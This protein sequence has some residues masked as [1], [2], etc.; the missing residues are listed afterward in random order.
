MTHVIDAHAYI[1]RSLNGFEQ[2]PEALLA[3]MDRLGIEQAAICPVRPM[4]YA[5]Q[6]QND[7]IAKQAAKHPGRFIALGRVDPR[8]PDAAKEV[9]RCIGELGAKGIFIHPWE[10]CFPVS[11]ARLMDPVAEI[12]QERRVPLM[13]ATGYPWVS[14]GMQVATIPQRFPDLP[15]IMTN[16][17]QIN[18]SGLGAGPASYT[19][20]NYPNTY[21]TTSGVYEELWLLDVWKTVGAGRVLFTSMSPLMDEEFELKR[22]QWA[23]TTDEAKALMLGDVAYRLYL[24]R[25]GAGK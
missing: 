14:E 19:L 18:I 10:D 11:D 25:P 2:T 13:I 15:V 5:Y 4:D 1:G 20:Q 7:L 22:I 17:G 12:C 24:G 3:E 21:I 8:Q 16:G 23:H 9:E 6:S